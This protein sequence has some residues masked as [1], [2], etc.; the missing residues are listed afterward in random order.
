MVGFF[1]TVQQMANTAESA[2]L[3]QA[4]IHMGVALILIGVIG[5]LSA[6]A[7]HLFTL[8]KLRRGETLPLSTWPLTVAISVLVSIL[9]LY[10]LWSVLHG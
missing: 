7:A 1:R 2:K 9:G 3:H 10:G 4:A 6:A 5:L 8:G